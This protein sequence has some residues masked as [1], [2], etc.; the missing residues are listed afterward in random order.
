MKKAMSDVLVRSI[1]APAKG[2]LEFVDEKCSGLTLRVSQSGVKAWALRYRPKG[3]VRVQRLSLGRFPAV[4]LAEARKLAVQRKLEVAGGADPQARV[5][6]SLVADRESVTVNSVLD[7]F[8]KDYVRVKTP[9]SA[10]VTKSYLASVRS[11]WG[12]KRAADVTREFIK[13]YLERKADSAPV[14]SNRIRSKLIQAFGWAV[15]EG[16]LSSSPAMR[17]PKYGKEVS[18]D[19]VIADGELLELWQAFGSLHKAM[20]SAFRLLALT[21][22][23]PGE[24]IQLRWEEVFDL[25]NDHARIEL[26]A[27]R[28]KNGRRH[29]IPLTPMARAIIEDARKELTDSEFVFPSF[30][31]PGECYDV[32]SFARAIKRI[33]KELPTTSETARRLKAN[34]PRPHDLRRTVITNLSRLGVSREVRKHVINHQSS[35]RDVL[36]VYDRYEWFEEKKYALSLWD[37]HL[38]SVI[39]KTHLREIA[40]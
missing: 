19:R 13:S 9:K 11:D 7:L 26:G 20:A 38:T 35:D 8:M 40:A 25:D 14:A 24:V 1:Q 18:R 12:H 10:V 27:S 16:L 36:A 28:T 5:R 4:S 29:T 33:I 23:R 2:R 6:Q 3:K 34:P 37:G 31:N 30:R 15:D 22:Q 21:G 39:T 32:R 17:L